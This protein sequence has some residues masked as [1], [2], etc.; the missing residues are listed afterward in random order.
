M[1]A[2]HEAKISDL[3]AV[4]DLLELTHSPSSL[5]RIVGGVGQV[6]GKDDKVRL[7]AKAVDQR[8]RVLKGDIRLWIGRTLETP[9]GIAQL[10]K[11]EVI[12]P[13]GFADRSHTRS[14]EP[15]GKHH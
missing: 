3:E 10:E 8:H 15:G 4:D 1:L 11:V 7:A 6:S 13:L 2:R 12:F 9:V 14:A 5:V